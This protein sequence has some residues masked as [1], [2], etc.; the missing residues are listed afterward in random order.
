MNQI[1]EQA[2]HLLLDESCETCMYWMKISAG[3][4][5]TRTCGY[6]LLDSYF[7]KTN[8]IC[9]YYQRDK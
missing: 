1:N 9:K 6:P 5:S 2:K 8:N 3:Y 4:V 7:E